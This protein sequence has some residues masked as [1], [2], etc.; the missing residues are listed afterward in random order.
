M[1]SAFEVP[2]PGFQRDN[3]VLR[4]IRSDATMDTKVE[5]TV[6]SVRAGGPTFQLNL[7]AVLAFSLVL[8][9][10]VSPELCHP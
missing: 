10:L 6:A 3:L 4:R 1:W 8:H 7:Q 2:R 5:A 9:E